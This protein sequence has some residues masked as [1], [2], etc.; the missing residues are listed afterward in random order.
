MRQWIIAL[1]CLVCCAQALAEPAQFNAGIVRL[2]VADATAPIDTLVFYPTHAAAAPWQAGPFTIDASRGAVPATDTRFPVVL[3]SHGRHAAPLSHRALATAL[4]RAGFIVI[5]PTHVGD[6]A[7]FPLAQTQARVLIDRPR[8]AQEALDAVLADRRFAASADVHRIGMIGYSAGGYTALI[9]AGAIPDF[10]YAGTYCAQHDDAGSCP[11]PASSNGVPGASAAQAAIA[12][13]LQNW[14]PRAEPRL[15]ALV[16]MDPLAVM[17]A[18]AGLAA[19][20]VP[21]L[22]YRP[23]DDSYLGATRNAQAVADGLPVPPHI[24]RVPGRHFVFIDPCPAELALAQP[25]ICQDAPG[26]D[27]AAIHRQMEQDI[28][29]FLH[30]HL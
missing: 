9:L 4:A 28:A 11:R 1:W 21:T 18:S 7:G 22:L 25:L 16:L 30:A 23:Y 19:V 26:V 3:I 6:A 17:F 29:A 2:T 14:Q 15:K 10:A 5:L 27:R 12:P 20:H 24:Q 13:E 8:Q